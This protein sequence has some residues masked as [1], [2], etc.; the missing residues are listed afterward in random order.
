MGY[1]VL[2]TYGL[3]VA[4]PRLPSWWTDFAMEYWGLWVVTCMGYEKF[5]CNEKLVHS[6]ADRK[7]SKPRKHAQAQVAL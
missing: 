3:W 5:Y 6:I 1:G 2:Q 4:N 7:E